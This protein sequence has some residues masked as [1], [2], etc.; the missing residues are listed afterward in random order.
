MDSFELEVEVIGRSEAELVFAFDIA[1]GGKDGFPHAFVAAGGGLMDGSP[2]AVIGDVGIG[3]FFEHPKGLLHLPPTNEL[4]DDG[5]VLVEA[6]VEVCAV[7]EGGFGEVHVFAPGGGGESLGGIRAALEEEFEHF[8][9]SAVGGEVGDVELMS[10]TFGEGVRIGAGIEQSVGDLEE[11]FAAIHAGGGAAL[12]RGEATIVAS[13]CEGGI[14]F[15]SSLRA[16]RVAEGAG[17][18]EVNGG[19]AFAEAIHKG[20]EAGERSDEERAGRGPCAGEFGIG[21]VGEEP[22]ETIES[23]LGRRAGFFFAVRFFLKECM[24]GAIAAPCG[25]EVGAVFA[26]FGER[27]LPCETSGFHDRAWA[28]GGI[29]PC[30]QVVP[31]CC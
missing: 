7:A 28:F 30:S 21:A 10:P 11:G 15:E 16:L 20:F 31:D 8:E 24:Q 13:R 23:G 19:P 14:R 29:G 12:E 9:V 2:A 18:I 22:V 27:L 3:A 5:A 6:V 1:A 26:Q 4:T 25:I 17:A